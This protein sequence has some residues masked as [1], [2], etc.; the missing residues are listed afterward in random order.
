MG[1]LHQAVEMAAPRT[2][3]V[4][5][6]VVDSHPIQYHYQYYR[7]LAEFSDIDLHVFYCWD[8]R[9]GVQDPSYGKVAWDVP[10]LEGYSHSFVTNRARQTGF[11]FM[12][13]INPGLFAELTP[14]RFDVVWIWGYSTVSAWI[15]AV[16]ARA[17]GLRVLFRGEATL[18]VPRSWLRRLAKE[19]IVRGFLRL[20]DGVAYS[21]AANRRYYEHYGVQPDALVF[22]PC[23]VDNSFFAL[24]GDGLERDG[25]RASLGLADDDRVVLFVG[26]LI[27]VKRPLDL[28]RVYEQ[29]PR[30]SNPVMLL[31]GDGPL[32]PELERYC[33]ERGIDNIRFVGFRNQTELA[34]YYVAA[35]LFLLTSAE[36]RSPKT[37]NEAMNFGLPAVVTDRVGTV[38]DLIVDGWNGFVVP[39]GDPGAIA[40]ACAR[41]LTDRDLAIRMRANAETRVAEWSFERGA[42]AIRQWL[43]TQNA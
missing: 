26:R 16:T 24:L 10:L 11:N 42:A 15:A 13:Q 32:R 22:A 4:R 12:G 18:D 39:C 6:A 33:Q 7:L 40:Q 41:I 28:L 43:V 20:V 19:A 27:D 8:T 36:D 35:D 25:C 2:R 30:D 17:R 9:A 38:G 34:R 14:D 31:V 5:L 29:L 21:C 23:A 3:K 1:S 37:L